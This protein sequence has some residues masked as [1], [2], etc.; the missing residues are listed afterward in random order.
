MVRMVQTHH[1]V[2]L[3]Q[4]VAGVAEADV[5]HSCLPDDREA[6]A[7]EQQRGIY[8]VHCQEELRLVDRV[9][10]EGMHMEGQTR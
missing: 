10:V 9:P 3:F 1:S 5:I 2:Q 8:P 4:L 7:A 6:P